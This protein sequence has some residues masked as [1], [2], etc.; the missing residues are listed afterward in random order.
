MIR[1]HGFLKAVTLSLI[2]TVSLLATVSAARAATKR[3]HLTP[4]EVEQVRAAQLLDKRI[5]VFIKVAERRLLL[6]ADPQAASSKQMQKE[7]EKWGEPPSGTRAELFTDL[8]KILDEAITNIDDVA[9]RDASN[10]L[11]P[12]SL[13]KLAVAANKFIGQLTPMRAQAKDENEREAL[14]QAMENAQLVIEAAN[15][16]PAETK[17]EGKSEKNKTAKP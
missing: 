9:A 11:L 8:A 3:D 6:L 12:K 1:R 4:L 10:R 5:E 14:E 7:T 2:T 16:L 15:R 13:R 17:E